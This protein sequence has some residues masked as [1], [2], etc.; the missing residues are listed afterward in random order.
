MNWDDNA[1]LISKNRYNEN[2]IIAEF[3]TENH[4]KFCYKG[5]KGAHSR[6]FRTANGQV[7]KALIYSYVGFENRHR[8]QFS[9]IYIWAQSHFIYYIVIKNFYLRKILF[10][11]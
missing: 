7:M 6:L 5:F 1:Y 10:Q 2:S 3:F 9:F 4:G 11:N 8:F